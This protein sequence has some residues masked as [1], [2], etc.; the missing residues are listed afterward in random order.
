VIHISD[1][2]NNQCRW[3]DGEASSL[4]YCGEPTL[5]GKSWCPGHHARAFVPRQKPV[6]K[7]QEEIDAAANDDPLRAFRQR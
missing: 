7:T 3:M 2:K 6:R 1:L 5:P 4:L